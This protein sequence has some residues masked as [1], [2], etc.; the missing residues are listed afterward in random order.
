MACK[1]RAQRQNGV[2]RVG[3][4]HRIAAVWHSDPTTLPTTT[5][6]CW[7]DNIKI[8]LKLVACSNAVWVCIYKCH[9]PYWGDNYICIL[10]HIKTV[11]HTTTQPIS[12]M[13]NSERRVHTKR[14][15]SKI[16][17]RFL[18]ITCI[19]SQTLTKTSRIISQ[20]SAGCRTETQNSIPSMDRTHLATGPRQALH[21]RGGISVMLNC[22][23]NEWS[24]K[25]LWLFSVYGQIT[26]YA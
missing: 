11:P 3:R 9:A 26:V 8:S 6:T 12:R 2:T 23:F 4:G 25:Q 7:N 15:W 22:W 5:F 14:F 17:K 20:Y 1:H 10:I 18:Q 24:L 19:S 21:N 13:C 16:Q